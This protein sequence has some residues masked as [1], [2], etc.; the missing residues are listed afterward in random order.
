[1]EG[2]RDIYMR[3]KVRYRRR[4]GERERIRYKMNPVITQTAAEGR[5]PGYDSHFFMTKKGFL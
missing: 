2:E 3:Y 5:H 1:M 4:E